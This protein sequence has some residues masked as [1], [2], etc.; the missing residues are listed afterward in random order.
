MD[1]FTEIDINGAQA[2]AIARGLFAIAR[3]DGVH[4]RELALIA[5]FYGDAGGGGRSLAE[6]EAREPIAPAELA[7]ALS[8]VAHR[9][10]FLKTGLLLGWVD[11][12]VTPAERALIEQYA[13]AM[14]VTGEGL[15]QLEDGV[16]EFLLGQVSHLKNTDATRQ[17]ARELKL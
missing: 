9:Q 14:G 4:E 3:V 7:A 17:V 2:E 15:T 10:L 5:S 13:A 12:Q 16:K 1:F 11:G 8:G 6:L